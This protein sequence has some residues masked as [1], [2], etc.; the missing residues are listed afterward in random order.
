MVACCSCYSFC[1]SSTHRCDSRLADFSCNRCVL[2]YCH[3]DFVVSSRSGYPLCLLRQSNLARLHRGRHPSSSWRASCYSQLVTAN[4]LAAVHRQASVLSFWGRLAVQS[5]RRRI[6]SISSLSDFSVLATVQR[7]QAWA[8]R[9]ALSNGKRII[10]V[11]RSQKARAVELNRTDANAS[12]VTGIIFPWCA[13]S[14][15]AVGSCR[16]MACG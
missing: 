4:T 10:W 15:R 16:L 13:V 12:A 3:L 1:P 2:A 9:N 5:A 14:V 8:S 6:L 11:N 7:F